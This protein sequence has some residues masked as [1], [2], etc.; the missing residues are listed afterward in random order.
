MENI[1]GIKMSK[2]NI[3][4]LKDI[5]ND[6]KEL[7][8]FIDYEIDNNLIFININQFAIHYFSDIN[9]LTLKLY[10]TYKLRP[11]CISGKNHIILCFD[12]AED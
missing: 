5:L 1:G 9:S 2:I 7:S 11:F 3:F 4:D 6:A 10:F 8:S 12:L